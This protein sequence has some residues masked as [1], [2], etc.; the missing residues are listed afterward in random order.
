MRQACFVL[1]TLMLTDAKAPVATR[2]RYG[3][4]RVK[5]SNDGWANGG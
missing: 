3:G 2:K 5:I 4:L 1:I